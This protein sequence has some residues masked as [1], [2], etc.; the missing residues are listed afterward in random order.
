MTSRVTLSHAEGVATLTR[1]ATEFYRR[2][3][4]LGTGGNLSVALTGEP[5]RFLVTAS[6]R[7]KGELT[8]DGFVEVDRDGLRLDHTAP[9]PSDETLIHAALYRETGAGAVYH[10][11]QVSAAVASTLDEEAGFIEWQDVEMLKGIGIPAR[12]RARLPIID[13]EPN[14]PALAEM[15]VAALQPGMPAVMIRRHGIYTWGAS[16][17]DAHRHVEI[18]EYLFQYRCGLAAAGA[19]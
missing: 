3:W 18:L 7:P 1:S 17:A 8:P 6:G 14:I 5:F 12:E 2:G 16:A 11:H 19:G 10:V 9:K 4:M 15:V 13:N